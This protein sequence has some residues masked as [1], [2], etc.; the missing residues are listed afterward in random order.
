MRERFDIAA[1]L[2]EIARLLE[3]KGENPFKAQAYERGASALESYA[4]DFDVLVKTGRLKE[5]PGIG[6]ALAAIIEEIYPTGE[7]WMLQQLREGMPPGALELSAVP[8]LNLKK[9]IALHDALGIEGIGDLK[10]ACQEGL[11]VGVK[12]FGL[13]SQAKL[14]SDIESLLAPQ[15]AALPL[16]HALAAGE[17]AL[18]HSVEAVSPTT[19]PGMMAGGACDHRQPDGG[20]PAAP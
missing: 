3:I 9:I 18:R 1:D 2:R 6:N 4:G 12:G 19:E 11:V 20:K 5:I 14:L 17:R 8:G 10:A 13:K 7:C 15:D 16:S